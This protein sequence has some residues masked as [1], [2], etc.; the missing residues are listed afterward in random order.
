MVGHLQTKRDYG[1]WCL[2]LPSPALFLVS[3]K[4]RARPRQEP[5]Y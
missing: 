5:A 1:K 4:D 2:L 3:A